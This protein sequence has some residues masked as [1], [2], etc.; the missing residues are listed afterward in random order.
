[1]A[2][3][4]AALNGSTTTY[5]KSTK[6]KFISAYTRDLKYVAYMEAWRAKIEAIGSLNYPGEEH[7]AGMTEALRLDVA[8]NADGTVHSVTLL[9]SSGNKVLDRAA[10]RI[11]HLAAPF[12]PFP[13]GI[14]KETEVLHIIYPWRF[15]RDNYLTI[16]R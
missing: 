3:L 13:Q 15:K 12:A 9:R 11:V 1:M 16:N 7:E 2:S 8:L 10:T 6:E 14:R 4:T 5:K